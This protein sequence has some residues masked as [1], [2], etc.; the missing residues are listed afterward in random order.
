MYLRTDEESEAANALFMANKLSNELDSDIRNWRWV[1][2]ALHNAAQGFMVLS[3][4]HGNGLLAL[5]KE[6]HAEW[7]EAYRNDSPTFPK[8]KL[9][10]YENLYKKV[11]NKSTGEFGGNTRFI[12]TG[13][14]GGSILKLN[15]IRNEF[16]HFTPKGWSLGVTGLPQVCIDCLA[17]ISFLGWETNNVF[18]HRPEYKEEARL[19]AERL[20]E[21]MK[22]LKKLYAT[23]SS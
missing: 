23:A 20:K 3:L 13:S 17:L 2:I 6:S 16:I 5:S 7:M 15:S 21:K 9:D 22:A 19:N 18:W 1:I 11:K 8:E 14:Q 10:S 4:R 12:P